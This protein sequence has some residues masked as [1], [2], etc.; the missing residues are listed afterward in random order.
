M[1]EKCNVEVWL[2]VDSCGDYAVG[3][4]RED[5]AE[6]YEEDVQS[7]SA[8]EGIRYVRLVRPL[9]DEVRRRPAPR[10]CGSR[11]F[12]LSLR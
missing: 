9:C 5:A 10:S 11:S 1:T 4:S 3:T 6:N 8:A 7:L 2:L 12:Q